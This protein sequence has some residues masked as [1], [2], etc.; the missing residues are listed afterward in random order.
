MRVSMARSLR[1]SLKIPLM[2]HACH[3]DFSGREN[4]GLSSLQY[5]RRHWKQGPRTTSRTYLSP[6]ICA[7]KPEFRSR[8]SEKDHTKIAFAVISCAKKLEA[9]HHGKQLVNEPSVLS[10]TTKRGETIS[11]SSKARWRIIGINSRPCW[12]RRCR[13]MQRW[14]TWLQA[15]SNGFWKRKRLHSRS[16]GIRPSRS[17]PRIPAPL[18][19]PRC[20][21]PATEH[22]VNHHRH[23]PLLLPGEQAPQESTNCGERRS[24]NG[25]IRL[26]IIL[27]CQENS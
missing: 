21:L 24:V 27:T 12:S 3:K 25:V 18:L 10:T 17:I 26:L 5:Q 1:K 6:R 22:V 9:A 7:T 20:Q 14:I 16:I 13:P 4:H 8:R 23:L 11:P 19:P 2:S 15:T